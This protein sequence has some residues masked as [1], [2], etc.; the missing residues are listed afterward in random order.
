MGFY[1]QNLIFLGLYSILALLA[2]EKVGQG[3][4]FAI[5]Q[6]LPILLHH[7][8]FRCR[9]YI[10]SIKTGQDQPRPKDWLTIFSPNKSAINVINR[11]NT[12]FIRVWYE[13]L[14]LKILTGQNPKTQ[15]PKIQ[16]P[17]R[18]KILT[19]QNPDR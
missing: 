5:Y 13:I 7:K 15:N 9:S 12:I 10:F 16:N 11:N 18:Y 8:N 14:K 6:S 17:D 1:D 3:P 2:L 19:D 4:N